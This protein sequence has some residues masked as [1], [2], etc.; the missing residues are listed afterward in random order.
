MACVLRTTSASVSRGTWAPTVH[1]RL[2][3]TMSGTVPVRI[4]HSPWPLSS[5]PFPCVPIVW[6]CV[7]YPSRLPGAV[8]RVQGTAYVWATTLAIAPLASVAP[9]VMVS[10][11][12][13]WPAAAVTW[14]RDSAPAT[15][16]A[17]VPPA[18]KEKTAP[19]PSALIAA[20][21]V[22]SVSLRVCASATQATKANGVIPSYNAPWSTTATA[23]ACVSMQRHARYTVV[24]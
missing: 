9:R 5:S 12:S 22:G 18:G 7:G 3:A 24:R 16:C 21:V 11:A 6:G 17:C 8:P 23:T 19:T 13:A 4:A 2:C 14:A 20:T 10:R 1:L 15:T